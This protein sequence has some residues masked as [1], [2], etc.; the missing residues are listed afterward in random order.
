MY[1]SPAA[2]VDYNP[3]AKTIDS[4]GAIG[5]RAEEVADEACKAF[6]E[7]IDAGGALD[8]HLA[9]QIIPYLA[10]ASGPSTFTTSRITQH[11]FTNIW[12]VKQFVDVEIHVEG[13]EGGPGIVRVLG[14]RMP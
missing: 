8:Q 4:L 14:R 5:K 12:V 7:Y 3:L 1:V 9:D 11:L 2:Q 6:F 13:N 10:L